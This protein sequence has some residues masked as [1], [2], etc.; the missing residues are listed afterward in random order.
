MRILQGHG[1]ERRDGGRNEPYGDVFVQSEH[2]TKRNGRKFVGGR[3]SFE[4][5]RN[6]KRQLRGNTA[7]I[8]KLRFIERKSTL[9]IRKVLFEV[10]W[11]Q[12][13]QRREKTDG[14]GQ[15]KTTEEEKTQPNKN[16]ERRSDGGGRRF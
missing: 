8:T 7:E 13:A 4:L 1:Q 15:K 11:R 5:R 6:G 10:V 12:R 16:K 9:P 14:G 3:D 2:G